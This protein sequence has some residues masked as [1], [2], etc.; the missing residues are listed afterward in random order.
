MKHDVAKYKT[1]VFDCDGVVLNSN[2]IKT[3]AFRLAALPYGEDAANQL[4]RHHIRNGGISRYKKF[5]HFL[6][7]IASSK[8]DFG[9]EVLL[10]RFAEAVT[11][12][13]MTC[14][15]A[16]GLTELRER[17]GHATWTIASGGDNS[18]L[19][20]VFARRGLAHLFDGGIHGSPEPKHEILARLERDGTLQ[21]P[22]LFLGDSVYDYEVARDAS[23]DFLFLS[24]WS[25]VENW[26]DFVRQNG[27]AEM[28]AIGDLCETQ[29]AAEAL[30]PPRDDT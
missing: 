28:H 29:R 19:N 27:L 17:T 25:E 15:V 22:A 23:I 13:L 8:Q 24:G 20:E 6:D 18:E 14:D 11:Q 1:L 9:F 10:T 12:G 5:E 3:D 30:K 21:R 4:V 2:R 26:Q 7:V 16:D